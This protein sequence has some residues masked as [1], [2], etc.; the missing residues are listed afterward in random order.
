MVD[1][2][3]DLFQSH[4]LILWLLCILHSLGGGLLRLIDEC[5]E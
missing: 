4:S 5:K 2:V 1:K 3:D